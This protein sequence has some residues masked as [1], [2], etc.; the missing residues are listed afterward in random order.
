MLEATLGGL[1]E[2]LALGAAISSSAACLGIAVRRG[3]RPS[4]APGAA[5][6]RATRGRHRIAVAAARR[7]ARRVMRVAAGRGLPLLGFL[8]ALPPAGARERA[9]VPP[10]RRRLA[11]V[12]PWSQSS[13]FSPPHPLDRTGAEPS[14]GGARPAPIPARRGAGPGAG[15]QPPWE[16]PHPAIHPERREA[17]EYPLFPRIARDPDRTRA[18]ERADRLTAMGRHP[19]GT[20]LSPAR[21]LHTGAPRPDTAGAPPS[22]RHA[23]HYVVRRGDSLWTIAARALGSDDPTRVVRYWPVLFRSNR[24]SLG[25]DPHLIFPGQVLRLPRRD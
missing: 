18:E 13:G 3:R 25:P 10:A 6:A 11:P 24:D 21:T 20:G 1:L 16:R 5:V 9:P 4:V 14:G 23:T 7:G 17:P 8:M 12:A 15:V 19:A 22:L 2:R